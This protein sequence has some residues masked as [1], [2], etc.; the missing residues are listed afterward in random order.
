MDYEY[1]LLLINGNKVNSK[2]NTIALCSIE[3]YEHLNKFK[4]YEDEW[5][6]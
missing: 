6:Y 2:N 3:D 1:K 4:W 5:I